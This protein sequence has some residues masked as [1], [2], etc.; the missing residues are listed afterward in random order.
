MVK[1]YLAKLVYLKVLRPYVGKHLTLRG[2]SD[3]EGVGGI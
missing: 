2:G 3:F 1:K